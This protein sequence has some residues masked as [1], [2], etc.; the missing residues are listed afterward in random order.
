ME[1]LLSEA[2]QIV[3]VLMVVDY[4]LGTLNAIREG[5]FNS[6]IGM[7]GVT[8]RLGLILI[9]SAIFYLQGQIKTN[10]W[11][12]LLSAQTLMFGAIVSQLS[13]IRRNLKHLGLDSVLVRWIIE[14][15]RDERNK[16]GS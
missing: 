16:N 11:I 8:K 15:K 7:K 2:F 10:D 5:R 12:V 3:I 1:T 13:S 14:D 4:L 9:V 6:D